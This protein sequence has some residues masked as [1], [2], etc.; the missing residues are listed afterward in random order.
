MAKNNLI[1][2]PIVQACR[3]FRLRRG[4]GVSCQGS[5]RDQINDKHM[6]HMNIL[7][8]KLL[9]IKH[10]LL[11]QQNSRY[12][13]LLKAFSVLF[14]ERRNLKK[15]CP[16]KNCHPYLLHLYCSRRHMILLSSFWRRLLVRR[17]Q[18]SVSLPAVWRR[19]SYLLGS[20][21]Y[22]GR[23]CLVLSNN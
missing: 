21:Y 2:L 14:N 16:W 1:C 9:C 6:W 15:I 17:K 13:Y 19:Y 4:G 5:R 18:H 3:N 23:F 12:T 22:N 7:A 20:T 8:L 10:N 11:L